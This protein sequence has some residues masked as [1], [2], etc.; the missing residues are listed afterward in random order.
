MRPPGKASSAA[1]RSAHRLQVTMLEK[2]VGLGL[3]L[4]RAHALQ[5]ILSLLAFGFTGAGGRLVA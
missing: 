4:L 5:G 2:V 3:K 1:A